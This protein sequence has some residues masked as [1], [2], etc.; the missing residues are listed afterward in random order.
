M[1]DP[2]DALDEAYRQNKHR[3]FPRGHLP[4]MFKDLYSEWVELDGFIMGLSA[5]ALAR[6]KLSPEEIEPHGHK[7]FRQKLNDFEKAHPAIAHPYIAAFDHLERML[8]LL[9]AI[10]RDGSP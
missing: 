9:R 7:E 8:E 10:T 2:Y 3:L 6:E 1:I 4:D 5:R